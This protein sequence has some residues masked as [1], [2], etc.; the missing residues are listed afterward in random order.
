MHS[1]V[2]NNL[3]LNVWNKILSDGSTK[4]QILVLETLQATWMERI[5]MDQQSAEFDNVTFEF[6]IQV[7]GMAGF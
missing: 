4:N 5:H 6:A 3:K 2:Y 7:I 1:K